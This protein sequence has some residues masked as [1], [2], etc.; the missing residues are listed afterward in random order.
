MM[1]IL[2]SKNIHSYSFTPKKLKQQSLLLRGL[3][4]DTESEAIKTELD[5]IVPDTVASVTKFKT[6]RSIKQNTDTGLFLVSLLIEKSL[7]SV[8][9]MHGLQNQVISWEKPEKKDSNI[10]CRRCQR[11]GHIARDCNSA[12][13]WKD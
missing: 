6:P 1:A 4:G 12:Y 8:P 7:S 11:W 5:A 13:N 3:V 2:R 9:K 10:Q